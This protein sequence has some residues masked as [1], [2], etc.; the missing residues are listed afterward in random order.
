MKSLHRKGKRTFLVDCQAI[1]SG[2][3]RPLSK[4]DRKGGE[5]PGARVRS[6][7]SRR[8]GGERQVPV[9]QG[10]QGHLRLHPGVRGTKAEMG[11]VTEPDMGRRAAGDVEV[12]RV[13]KCS[14]VAV[15]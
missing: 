10:G 12:V 3:G 9:E 14:W 8:I 5:T 2:S 7:E 1:G 15:G 13:G 4:A 11:A 6:A